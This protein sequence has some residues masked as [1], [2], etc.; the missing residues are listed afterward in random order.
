M[1]PHMKIHVFLIAFVVAL[2]IVFAGTIGAFLLYVPV[3]TI[4]SVSAVL[5]GF[6]VMFGLG[7]QAGGRRIR[8][9][10]TKMSPHELAHTE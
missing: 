8:V 4:F 1:K 7:M 3:L 9:K 6:V 2:G 5:F 10:R